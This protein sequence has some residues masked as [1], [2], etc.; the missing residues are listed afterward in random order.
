MQLAIQAE[1][2]ED[3]KNERN[4]LSDVDRQILEYLLGQLNA[5]PESLDDGNSGAVK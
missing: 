1:G 4:R 3:A 2:F 5:A